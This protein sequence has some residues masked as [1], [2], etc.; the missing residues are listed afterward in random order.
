MV[1][2]I[3]SKLEGFIIIERGCVITKFFSFSSRL[4]IIRKLHLN[5]RYWGIIFNVYVLFK[6]CHHWIHPVL[7]ITAGLVSGKVSLRFVASIGCTTG[8]LEEVTKVRV[9]RDESVNVKLSCSHTSR[10]CIS[11]DG[12]GRVKV[13]D[14]R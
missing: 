7:L 11:R 13:R 10:H 2:N 12:V 4:K 6:L 5:T 9:V 3:M 8:I 1:R 14:M